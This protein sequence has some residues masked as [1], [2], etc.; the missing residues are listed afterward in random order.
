MKFLPLNKYL[1][2]KI[3]KVL[4]KDLQVVKATL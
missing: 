4:M 1:G 2:N 3:V